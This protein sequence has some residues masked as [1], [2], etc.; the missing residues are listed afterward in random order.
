[1]YVEYHHES[2]DSIPSYIGGVTNMLDYIII[3]PEPMT[4][5]FSKNRK[6]L[7]Y[8]NY[9]AGIQILPGWYTSQVTRLCIMEQY[10]ADYQ[11]GIP[12]R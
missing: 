4:L 2:Q 7:T 1:M 10:Q 12:G 3:I 9:V 5:S 6:K 8:E 11:A